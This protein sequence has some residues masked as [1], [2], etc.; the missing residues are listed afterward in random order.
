MDNL[1]ARILAFQ[2]M[3]STH[4]RADA[5]F[6]MCRRVLGFRGRQRS[7]VVW[8]DAYE[9]LAVLIADSETFA[10]SIRR[11]VEAAA[12]KCGHDRERHAA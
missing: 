6:A 11:R 3:A 12:R 5:V 8:S 4:Q 10:A 9:L 7:R 1:D 2:F